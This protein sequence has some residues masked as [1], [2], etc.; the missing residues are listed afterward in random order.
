MQ[1]SVFLVGLGGI[2]VKYDLEDSNTF[3]RTH[4]RAIH[5]HTDFKLVGGYDPSEESRFEFSSHY[6]EKAY[7]NLE[8]G[9]RETNP[10]IVVVASPTEKHLLNI[11]EIL[12]WS[13]P[14]IILCEKPISFNPEDA[15][16]ILQLCEER[17]IPLF[18][19]YFRNSEPSTFEIAEAISRKRMVKPFKGFC[20]YNKGA[21]HTAT[22]FLN[23]F[24]IWFGEGIEY[25]FESEKH[26]SDNPQDPNLEFE[27]KYENGSITFNVD[28]STNSLRFY[29]TIKFSN[30]L[31]E[32]K[33]E[34]DRISWSELSDSRR[35]QD[36]DFIATE[37][38][39]SFSAQ[40]QF[41]V[42]NEISNYL[43]LKKHRLCTAQ[44]AI[45]YIIQISK[46]KRK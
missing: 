20:T 16:R 37:E 3:G 44:E 7:D 9:L 45:Q 1:N 40:S 15:I 46:L 28:D 21:L 35:I 27:V 13:N 11:Q 18:I 43:N 25:I 2:A 19:N 6:L 5:N 22:H 8:S 34:G 24:Q 30:G 41:N 33:E 31:L 32:Y 29:S 23:L 12:K 10:E 4:A 36:Q 38:I 26:N 14:R 42:W 39:V 17:N